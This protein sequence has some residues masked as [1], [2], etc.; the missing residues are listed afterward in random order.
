MIHIDSRRGSTELAPYLKNLGVPIRL[1]I[2][3]S[4]DFAWTGSGPDG[5]TVSAGVERKTIT[6]LLQSRNEGRLGSGQIPALCATYDDRYLLIEVMFR[7]GDGGLLLTWSYQ[8]KDWA[9]ITVHRGRREYYITYDEIFKHA[10]TFCRGANVIPI[11]TTDKVHTARVLAA[12]YWHYKTPWDDHRSLKIL[13]Q[14]HTVTADTVA[15]APGLSLR[16]D[17][18]PSPI[19]MVASQLPK[20]GYKKSAEV[21]KRFETITQMCLASIKSFYADHPDPVQ[22][23]RDELE[24]LW[25]GVGRKDWSKISGVGPGIVRQVY[26]ALNKPRNRQ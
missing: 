9:P 20:I 26:E 17:F 4:A 12:M 21:E 23:A 7:I 16:T 1:E 18:T 5:T 22:S 8:K 10:L 6:D 14:A 24:R 13:N 15:N 3:E 25:A 2:M 19:R 11:W